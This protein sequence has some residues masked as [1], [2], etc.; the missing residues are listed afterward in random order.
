MQ[1]VSSNFRNKEFKTV[2]F[3]FAAEEVHY[4]DLPREVNV[5]EDTGLQY[6]KITGDWNPHHLFKYTA[7]L[8]GYKAPI[9]HGMWTLSRV[10]AVRELFG[11]KLS[12]CHFMQRIVF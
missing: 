11:K 7:W 9:A 5:P 4:R 1:L 12:P 10:L 3:L 8:L 6:A 2:F